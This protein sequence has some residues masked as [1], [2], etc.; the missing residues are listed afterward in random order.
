MILA[1]N[2]LV[3]HGMG[4]FYFIFVFS[5]WKDSTELSPALIVHFHGGGFIAQTS[6][7]HQV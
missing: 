6:K 5:C 7:S 1:V 4:Y 2:V 3:Y